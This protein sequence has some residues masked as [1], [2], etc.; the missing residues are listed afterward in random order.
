[1]HCLQGAQTFAPNHEADLLFTCA[2]VRPH[3]A[4]DEH[5]EEVVTGLLRLGFSTQVPQVILGNPET[6]QV[7]HTDPLVIQSAALRAGDQIKELLRLRRGQEAGIC[8]RSP[9]RGVAS[10]NK[11]TLH[12]LIS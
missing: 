6:R 5:V 7:P 9:E 12:D 2:D 10:G 4:L 1:M 3:L 11:L 8:R